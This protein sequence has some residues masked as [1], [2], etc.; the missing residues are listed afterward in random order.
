MKAESN[1]KNASAVPIEGG[2]TNTKSETAKL[3]DT[4][5]SDNPAT[6]SVVDSCNDK[7]TEEGRESKR[8]LNPGEKQGGK[9]A[10]KMELKN[11]SGTALVDGKTIA[12][13][14]PKRDYYGTTIDKSRKQHHITFRDIISG[15]QIADVKEVE[16]FKEFNV[17]SESV[18]A[19]CDCSLL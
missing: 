13:S 6:A 4:A 11:L 19:Q 16:S 12:V 1:E 18:N 15:Q 10:E 17:L 9:P 7:R 8:N 3:A 2:E 5:K 14:E